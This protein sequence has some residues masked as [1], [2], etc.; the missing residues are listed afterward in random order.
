MATVHGALGQSDPSAGVLTDMYTVLAAKN[1]T[2]RVIVTNRSSIP[3]TFRIALAPGGAADSDEQYL[4]Y[5]KQIAGNDSG[6]TIAFKMGSLDV[7][8]VLATLATLS[9]TFT[10]MEQDN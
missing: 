4:A 2:G 1:A 6:S 8:R 7:L 3:T 5:D 10:G 9:F